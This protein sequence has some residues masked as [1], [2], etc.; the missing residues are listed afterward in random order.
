MKKSII[1]E[2]LLKLN[3]IP[4]LNAQVL[5]EELHQNKRVIDAKIKITTTHYNKE[6]LVEVKRKIVPANIPQIIAQVEDL[7]ETILFTDYLT[8]NTKKL[9]VDKNIAYTDTAGNIFINDDPI[10]IHIE[11]NKTNRTKLPGANRAFN[12]T[13]VKVLFLLLANPEYVNKPF[14][15]IG[16]QV[17]VAIDTVG[18]VFRDLRNEKYLIKVDCKKYKWNQREDLIMKWIPDPNGKIKVIE[19]FWIGEDDGP[20]VPLLITYA[21]LLTHDDPRYLEVANQVYEQIRKHII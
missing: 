4:A 6:W 13:S 2:V 1:H 18:K 3:E 11:T 19:K 14:R 15:F 10:Y 21:D 20:C 7:R 9:L 5:G 17:H 12:K 8:E 16:N